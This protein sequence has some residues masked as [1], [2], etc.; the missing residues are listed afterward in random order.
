MAMNQSL[1]VALIGVLL[2]YCSEVLG[3]TVQCECPSI[4]AKGTGNSDCSASESGGKCIIDFNTFDEAVERRAQELVSETLQQR[5]E[6]RHLG[7]R[8]EFPRGLDQQAA[9]FLRSQNA[10]TDQ[11]LVYLMVATVQAS[12]MEVDEWELRQAFESA[13]RHSDDVS[14]AFMGGWNSHQEDG[15][16]VIHGCI[17]LRV[18]RLWAMYKSKFSPSAASPRCELRQ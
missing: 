1:T 12:G 17:E 14:E 8:T 9:Q 10:L 5:I 11:L 15:V 3:G 6:F 2:L 16:F 18:S 13:R 7:F 4:D